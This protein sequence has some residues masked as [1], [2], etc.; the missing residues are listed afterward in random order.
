V[1]VNLNVDVDVSLKINKQRKVMRKVVG[2]NKQAYTQQYKQA[3]IIV[4]I[5]N[6]ILPPYLPAIHI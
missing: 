3:L 6:C 5:Q 1:V 2:A 4:V